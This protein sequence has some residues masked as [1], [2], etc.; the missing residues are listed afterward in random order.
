MEGQPEPTK[1]KEK[2][3]SMTPEYSQH[4]GQRNTDDQLAADGKYKGQPSI[5]INQLP[6]RSALGSDPMDINNKLPPY[7]DQQAAAIPLALAQGTGNLGK[8]VPG[9]EKHLSSNLTPSSGVVGLDQHSV[10]IEKESTP[11][12]DDY[13]KDIL[14]IDQFNSMISR[15]RNLEEGKF[16]F[17]IKPSDRMIPV[18]PSLANDA[19]Y[20]TVFQLQK[21]AKELELELID[22]KLLRAAWLEAVERLGAGKIWEGFT[23]DQRAAY[24]RAICLCARSVEPYTDSKW[25]EI[26]IFAARLFV[27]INELKFVASSKESVDL[28]AV[29]AKA[30]LTSILP[31]EECKGMGL[32]LSERRFKCEG[33]C[34]MVKFY[35]MFNKDNGAPE[36]HWCM[37][38]IKMKKFIQRQFD[39]SRA[40]ASSI[41]ANPGEDIGDLS[42]TRQL[43]HDKAPVKKNK[44]ILSWMNELEKVEQEPR[45]LWGPKVAPEVMQELKSKNTLDPD[46]AHNTSA[47]SATGWLYSE[48]KNAPKH[49]RFQYKAAKTDY[50]INQIGDL[51]LTDTIPMSNDNNSI[52]TQQRTFRVPRLRDLGSI[53]DPH[54]HQSVEWA[55]IKQD[56]V[57]SQGAQ[58][59][60]LNNNIKDVDINMSNSIITPELVKKPAPTLWELVS[61]NILPCWKEGTP[62]HL[63][64]NGKCFVQILAHLDLHFVELAVRPN[65]Q[66][67]DLIDQSL[68]E[69][70]VPIP[71]STTSRLYQTHPKFL[72][73]GQICELLKPIAEKLVPLAPQNPS[74]HHL[75]TSSIKRPTFDVESTPVSMETQTM[76]DEARQKARSSKE[77]HLTSPEQEQ[78]KKLDTSNYL[79][80][81]QISRQE[82]SMNSSDH[83]Q[84]IKDRDVHHSRPPFTEVF[85]VASMLPTNNAHELKNAS[86]HHQA[87]QRSLLNSATEKNDLLTD[88]LTEQLLSQKVG[89]NEA[90]VRSTMLQAHQLRQLQ[91]SNRFQALRENSLTP[92]VKSLH[93]Q[94]QTMQ[95]EIKALMDEIRQDRKLEAAHYLQCSEDNALTD[96]S[97]FQHIQG[98]QA[99]KNERDLLEK[100]QPEKLLKFEKGVQKTKVNTNALA[101]RIK[102]QYVPGGSNLKT[103]QKKSRSEKA[104]Q[105]NRCKYTGKEEALREQA[106]QEE[107]FGQG[108]EDLTRMEKNRQERRST[109]KYAPDYTAIKQMPRTNTEETK[110]LVGMVAA[111]STLSSHRWAN[112]DANASILQ[113][114][115][116]A[117][118]AG[119]NAAGDVPQSSSNSDNITSG[120]MQHDIS[121]VRE[122]PKDIPRTSASTAHISFGS[123][124]SRRQY[125]QSKYTRTQRTSAPAPSPSMFSGSLKPHQTGIRQDLRG[126][127]PSDGETRIRELA[128]SE[129][130]DKIA[131]K[132]LRRQEETKT[133][134]SLEWAQR[135][136]DLA[137][138]SKDDKA[139]A[140][141][142]ELINFT[143]VKPGGSTPEAVQT[144]QTTNSEANKSMTTNT[145]IINTTKINPTEI[146]NMAPVDIISY[147]DQL[148]ITITKDPGKTTIPVSTGQQFSGAILIN[149]EDL[150]TNTLADDNTLIDGQ[151]EKMVDPTMPELESSKAVAATDAVA[152]AHAGIDSGEDGDIDTDAE[153]GSDIM[154]NAESD[155]GWVMTD[156]E[157]EVLNE[158]RVE[159]DE[160]EMV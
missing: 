94:S 117:H 98:Q 63:T 83:S 11:R 128:V 68:K 3:S 23:S 122:I 5:E 53:H 40:S 115:Q 72:L 32:Q 56:T 57:K 52:I 59:L 1:D 149:Q 147:N 58:A 144:I 91:A 153:M 93:R 62:G 76:M 97:T 141:K 89:S 16:R 103:L 132:S 100:C 36:T 114:M 157:D 139:I 84:E 48:R 64:I 145:E 22:L 127:P 43:V 112:G 24:N 75:S 87:R 70:F 151:S 71:L 61:N 44:T 90:E 55:K 126:F 41:S 80:Q 160:W 120:S 102:F 51:N 146:I 86:E 110:S 154:S 20:L 10:I 116:P 4:Q 54:P 33:P 19:N 118:S 159:G 29:M 125:R 129:G 37:V 46:V 136:M 148:P 99:L 113:S 45:A 133:P 15:E 124:Q 81:S 2:S 74:W 158:V 121:A 82:M 137:I 111:R 12:I 27:V 38:C 143:T 123:P 96:R 108:I 92:K 131:S 66:W 21:R 78:K 73:N 77:L 13:T 101:D 35:Y 134:I 18:Q 130:F 6:L 65:K 69:Q 155:D 135:E 39:P 107:I 142:A 8:V 42:T 119:H 109:T 25:N 79:I 34:G 49:P 152:S 9:I 95:Q 156:G 50:S 60:N 150:S 138:A 104:R 106:L 85:K 105:E 17:K 31:I 14:S 47:S 88:Q 26:Q 7:T 67:K 140:F 28:C 30:S